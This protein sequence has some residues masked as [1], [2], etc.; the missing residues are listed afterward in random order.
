MPRQKNSLYKIILLITCLAILVMGIVLF[1]I[2]PALFPDPEQ[3]FQVLRCMLSGGGFNHLISPDQSDISQNYTEFLTWWSPGQYLVPYLFKLIAGINTG[4]AIAFAVTI[5]Q[6]IGLAGFYAFFKKTGFTP[7]VAATSLVFIICQ[8]AFVVPF[9]YYNGGEVLIFAFEGWFLYG[10]A[11]LKKPGIK[12]VVFV[13]VSGWIGF[14]LKS[15]FLWIYI[16]GLCCLWIRLSLNNA[17]VV[18]WIKKGLLIG[19]PAAVSLATIYLFY[20]SK[21]QSPASTANGFK[22]TAETFSFPLASPVLSGFSVDDLVHGLIY[23]TGKPLFNAQWSTIILIIIAVISA[24]FILRIISKVPNS[25]YSLF[26]TVF[27]LAALFIFGF[28][29]LHQLNISYEA[30][31]F[32]IIG[33][34]I[35]PGVIYL[36]GT[37]KPGYKFLCALIFAGIAYF[38]FSY[39]IKGYKIN[40]RNARGRSGIAQTDIDQQSLN[41]MMKLDRENR[42]ATFVFVSNDIGLEILHNRIITLQPIGDDLKINADDYTYKGFAGPLYIVLP[43]SYNGPKEKMVMKSFPGYTGWD[44]SMLSDNY[45]LYVAKMKR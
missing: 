29:Y 1:F 14:F 7:L 3:G 24:L 9:V 30:R 40:Y 20:I 44:I 42:N 36:V 43:E 32:R 5:C 25:H 15:S 35:V 16:A 38:S 12:F 34:L 13:L 17:G 27:Y 37:F 21:G 45:V 23:H 22:L 39:L 6:L 28:S 10:C 41:T 8:V 18:E 11:A 33:I 19:L 26:I 2:P 4:H 31:H